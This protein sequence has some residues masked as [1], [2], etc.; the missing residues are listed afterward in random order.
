MFELDTAVQD[1]EERAGARIY[2]HGRVETDRYVRV[3]P[4]AP[5][6]PTGDLL[7]PLADFLDRAASTDADHDNSSRL[8]VVLG[9]TDDP[10]V[11][12]PHLGR[13]ALI[14]VA[15]ESFRDGRG[16]ST[17]ALVRQRLGWRGE[18]RVVGD[19]YRD[20]VLPLH[21]VGFDSFELPPGLEPAE[22]TEALAEFSVA[23]QGSLGATG[24]ALPLFRLRAAAIDARAA[25][26][27][28][29]LRVIGRDHPGAALASSLSSE[30]MVLTD[31]IARH[32]L[33]IAVFTLDTG[34][35]HPE[36]VAMIERTRERYGLVIEVFRPRAEAVVTF[37]SRHGDYPMYESI[38]LR[39][40]CCDLRKVEPLGRALAGRSAWLT[41]QRRAQSVT[42]T[43][44]PFD[45]FDDGRGVPKFNPLADWTDEE[46]R[47]YLKHH[48]VPYNPLHDRGYP[49]IGCE[50]CTRAIR[51]GED[52]RA[53]RW[54]WENADSRECGLHVPAD[55]T[56]PA[57]A[58]ATVAT[59]ATA[60]ST[61][62][63]AIDAPPRS[64]AADAAEAGGRA[65]AVIVRAADADLDWLEAESIDVLREVAG[66]FERPTLLFSGGKDSCVV[67]HLALKAFAPG[68]LPFALT[69]VDTGHNFPEVIT[70]RDQLVAALGIPL[71]VAS[72]EDSITR[73][74]VVLD[75]PLASRNVAQ[76]TTL[77]EAI[78]EHRF[79]ALIGGARRDEE[80]ARAKERVFSHRDT[81]GQWDPKNQR[82][83]LWNLYNTRIGSGEHMR[84][85]PISNWTELDVW[86]YIARE[87]I[88]L[89]PIYFAHRRQVYERKGL[90]VPVTA[91][92]PPHPEDHV[93]ETS[94]RFRTV[95]DMSCTC[96]V[97]SEA[98]D[99]VTI[100][101]ETAAARISERAA[102]RMDD[103]TSDSSMERRKREGYF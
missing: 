44:L 62:A 64:S 74:T 17:A 22:V 23:Y 65:P 6:P 31:L 11:L 54:W 92:T 42:R 27:L 13:V 51:P 63:A 76:A 93:F 34:R 32:A 46:V 96:P 85:F 29:R 70:F 28:A 94:V 18:L 101:A 84:V 73:G 45:E 53:G 21:R 2:R 12:A 5:I 100:V 48:D 77:L 16:F 88:A 7:Y 95:G 89:P 71:I 50:P 14:A 66:D 30:D 80:K 81:F 20:Q 91:L 41:G 24:G 39:K 56:A 72:V 33:P 97:A 10:L 37:T 4:G 60:A 49:S 3:A 8:G 55:R 25:E 9:P 103:R 19:F 26:V 67:L 102:T 52:P 57:P 15:F 90:L 43:D 36:T 1:A 79:D 61:A 35:L 38:D 83:E 82:A 86:R 87:S 59:V 69:H 98:T 40:A 47:A 99:S 75:G 68:V 58:D 78:D